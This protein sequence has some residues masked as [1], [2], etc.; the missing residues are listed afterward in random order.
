VR[1]RSGGS[2]CRPGAAGRAVR[3]RGSCGPC[4]GATTGSCDRRGCASSGGSR[5]PCAGGGC[6]AGTY[7]C[8]RASLHTGSGQPH[9]AGTAVH[10][11]SG[12]RIRDRVRLSAGTAHPRDDPDGRLLFV[13]M[14]HRST[15]GDRATVRA[16]NPQG[17]TRST[18]PA[19]C[20]WM[21]SC[22]WPPNLVTFAGT[23]VPRR[24]RSRTRQQVV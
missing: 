24:P 7:A 22:R 2:T 16:G 15:P 4:G 8:S 1:R 14:R 20:L 10:I 18:P 11:S 12:P 21:T 19:S 5:A 6:S 13:D 17:Q 9:R 23:E 3:P